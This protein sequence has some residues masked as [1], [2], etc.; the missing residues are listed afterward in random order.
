MKFH[1]LILIILALAI[2][3]FGQSVPEPPLMKGETKEQRKESQKE[4]KKAQREKEKS[5]KK[6]QNQKAMENVY[7]FR[8]RC[9]ISAKLH[10]QNRPL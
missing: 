2:G 6:A 10:R 3:A 5:D 9:F 7:D 1:I 4:S 8:C